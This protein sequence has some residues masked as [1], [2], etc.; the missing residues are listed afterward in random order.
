MPRTFPASMPKRVEISPSAL[1]LIYSSGWV[2]SQ[3]ICMNCVRFW[4]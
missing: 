4:L 2:R 3:K 1:A